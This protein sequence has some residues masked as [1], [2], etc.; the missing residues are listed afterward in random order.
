MKSICIFF[1]FKYSPS[2]YEHYNIR[3]PET[4]KLIID[5]ITGNLNV[6]RDTNE[7]VIYRIN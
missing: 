6:L 2:N 1:F 5:R 3:K 4:Y 7:I